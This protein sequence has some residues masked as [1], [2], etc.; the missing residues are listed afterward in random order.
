MTDVSDGQIT[1]QQQCISFTAVIWRWIR[2][3]R[4]IKQSTSYFTVWTFIS[5]VSHKYTSLPHLP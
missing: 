2:Q 4:S 5:F 1:L 3:T